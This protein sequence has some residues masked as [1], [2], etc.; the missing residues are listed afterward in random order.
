MHMRKFLCLSVMLLLMAA[1]SWAQQRTVTGTVTDD[2]GA[3]LANVSVIIKG[4]KSGTVTKTDGT[5]SVVVP[6]GA[7]TLVFSFAGMEAREVAISDDNVVNASLALTAN[8]MENIVVVGYG[9]QQKKAFT[10]SSSKVNAQQI[11][12]LMTPSVDKELAGRAA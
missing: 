1:Q 8:T 4:T 12:T 11:S 5:Y 6:A 3:A 2:K 10:G 7:R 9:V